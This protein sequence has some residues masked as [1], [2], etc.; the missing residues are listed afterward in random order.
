MAAKLVILG[1]GGHGRALIELV[2]ALP[3]WE[4]VGLVDSAADAQPQLG[5]PVLG[6]EDALPS[7]RASGI[8]HAVV[9][10]GA[11]AARLRVAERL[12]AAGFA[13]PPLVHPSAVIAGSA[14]L[15]EGT[16]ALPRVVVGAAA[17]IGALCIL[18]TG[19]ILEHDAAV[20]DGAHIGPGAVLAG[21]VTVGAG[22]LVGAGAAV[23]PYARIGD[24]AVVG[25]GAAVVEDVAAG[26]TVGG[27]PARVI[28]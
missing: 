17:R 8:G 13:L 23:R 22:A 28:G 25:T 5:L 27:V 7:L 4:A 6:Q 18:N 24:G 21:G 20:G 3:D 16:V 19:A 9:A 1:A 26:T 10:I 2:R 15:G 11:S 12:R 14:R